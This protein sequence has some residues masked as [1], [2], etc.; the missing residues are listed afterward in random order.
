MTDVHHLLAQIALHPDGVKLC[1]APEVGDEEVELIAEHKAWIIDELRRTQVDHAGFYVAFPN[2]LEREIRAASSLVL[3]IEVTAATRYCPAERVH[4]YTMIGQHRWAEYRAL[5]PGV[6]AQSKP[7]IRAIGLHVDGLG[8]ICF[9]WDQ[10]PAANKQDLLEA[11]LANKV[12]IGHDLGYQLSWLLSETKARPAYVADTMIL[13]QHVRPN[14]LWRPFA[15]AASSDPLK[16]AEA[17]ALIGQHQGRP[18]TTLDFVAGSFGIADGHRQFDTHGSWCLSALSDRHRKETCDKL[19]SIEQIFKELFAGGVRNTFIED[20]ERAAPLY[21]PYATA[22]LRLAEAHGRGVPFDVAASQVMRDRIEGS[23]EEEAYGDRTQAQA[24]ILSRLKRAANQDGRVHTIVAFGTA[25]GRTASKYPALQNLPRDPAWR[26]LIRARPYHCILSIDYSAIELRVAAA[27]ASR[28]AAD[29]EKCLASGVPQDWFLKLV[30]IGRSA[31]TKYA[32]PTCPEIGNSEW[33]RDLILAAAQRVFRNGTQTMKRAFQQGIDLHLVTAADIAR[34]CGALTME[35]SALDWLLSKSGVERLD[36]EQRLGAERQAAKACNFGLLYGMSAKGLHHYAAEQYGLAWTLE[37]AVMAKDAWLE[38][39]PEI[40]LWHL[41]T[42]YCQ[43]REVGPTRL[44]L[45]N[46]STKSLSQPEFP[47]RLFETA[48]LSGRP[49]R[50]LA[51]LRQALSYQGQGTGAD[52]MA[53]AISQIPD[54]IAGMLLLP[55]HDELL[56]EVP[57]FELETTKQ[58]VEQIMI[59]AAMTVLGGDIPIQVKSYVGETWS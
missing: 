5:H 32:W 14:V 11:I 4:V 17:A 31:E 22:T 13:V 7:R 43:S 28:A 57:V 24:T 2:V 53:L 55:V 49:V 39:Y 58:T 16:S 6:L 36:L 33:Y 42:R 20:I 51:N 45:W 12:I 8:S 54:A 21:R 9:N 35:G 10:L 25:T 38:I 56:L 3:S 15:R 40:S 41:W 47:V 59:T 50:A 27:L 23:T 34:R 48:T 46:P 30:H 29:I 37:E 26:R 18:A 19:S 1:I 44:K 52:I